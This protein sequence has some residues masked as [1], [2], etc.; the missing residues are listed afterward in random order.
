MNNHN[1]CV[2]LAGGI[3]SRFWP[4]SRESLP[5]QFLR[6]PSGGGSFLQQTWSRMRRSFAP[7][8]IYVTSLRR[9]RDIVLE[10]LPDLPEENLLLEPYSRNTAPSITF[11]AYNLLS[12]DPDAVMVV[13]PADHVIRDAELFDRTI[14]QAVRYAGDGEALVT[15]GIVPTRPDTNFGYIQV[16]G[17]PEIINEGVP[18]KAKTFTE[19][20]DRELAEVFVGS[21]EFLWNSGIFIWKASA[22]VREIEKHAPEVAGFWKGWEKYVP[23]QS[24]VEFVEKAYSECPKISVDYAVMEKSDSVWILPSKFR[25]ADIGTWEALYENMEDKDSS[26]N[27]RVVAGN[28]VLKD[29]KGSFIYSKDQGKLSLICGLEDYMVVDTGDVL[30]ICPRDE[31][32][33]KELLSNMA[34]PEFQDYR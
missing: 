33:L 11:A 25:W 13:T 4:V 20:P 18:V 6:L 7:E 9:Y 8:H 28:S 34:R 17:G 24:A 12:R 31:R 5:K 22:I 15:L 2:I 1:Y 19:K 26:H 32:K 3:G 23:L 14:G 21:G 10:Q 30:L 27:V 29:V 16:S